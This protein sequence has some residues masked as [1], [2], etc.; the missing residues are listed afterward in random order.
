MQ[1]QAKAFA[2]IP[3][4]SRLQR[5]LPLQVTWGDAPSA[6]LQLLLDPVPARAIGNIIN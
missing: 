5:I 4:P 2:D 3:S 1:S 6:S